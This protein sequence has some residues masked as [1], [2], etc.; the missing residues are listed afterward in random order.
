MII[1]TWDEFR[2]T[3]QDLRLP[4]IEASFA[5]SRITAGKIYV[6]ETNRFA[7]FF[8][9]AV[10]GND[11][12]SIWRERPLQHDHVKYAIADVLVLFTIR[13]PTRRPPSNSPHPSID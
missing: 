8:P 2:G 12:P 11:G 6:K 10:P 9:H 7:F 4:P 5:M 1:A 13:N 3:T